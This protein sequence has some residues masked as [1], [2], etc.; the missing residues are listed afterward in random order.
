MQTNPETTDKCEGVQNLQKKRDEKTIIANYY[1]YNY[2]C[3]LILQLLCTNLQTTRRP[4]ELSIK[5]KCGGRDSITWR[6]TRAG[7]KL[8]DR[9]LVYSTTLSQCTSARVYQLRI[10][11]F[12]IHSRIL[13]SIYNSST[14]CLIQTS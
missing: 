9:K 5:G 10:W 13:N 12:W 8:S 7:K 11:K 3:W 1:N 2:V 6:S 14:H 4:T